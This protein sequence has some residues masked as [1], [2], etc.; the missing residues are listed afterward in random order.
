MFSNISNRLAQRPILLGSIFAGLAAVCYGS[1]QFLAS[2]LVTKE[3]PPLVVAT[4]GL[5]VGILVL[6]AVSHRSLINDRGAP[7]R[8]FL[9]MALSGVSASAAVAFSY[10]A[11]SLAPVIVVA[12]VTSITP[13]VSLAIAHLFLQ[14]LEKITLRIW[15]GAVLVVTGVIIIALGST[16]F[17]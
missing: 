16:S 6:S 10:I 11:L 17:E 14:R 9:F 13:L 15:I 3:T 2:K 4:F 12:P 5:L 8:A 1:S 7:K